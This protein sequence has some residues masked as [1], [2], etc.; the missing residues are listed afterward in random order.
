MANVMAHINSAVLLTFVTISGRNMNESQ[1][2]R[3]TVQN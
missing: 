2:E 1:N 3:E